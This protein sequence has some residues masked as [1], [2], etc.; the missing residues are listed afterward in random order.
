MLR[1]HRDRRDPVRLP[2]HRNLRRNQ[3]R[4]GGEGLH[5]MQGPAFRG[6]GKR[7]TQRPAIDG[8]DVIRARG[9]QPLGRYLRSGRAL[10]PE[11]AG[12]CTSEWKC[13]L[14][15]VEANWRKIHGTGVRNLKSDSTRRAPVADR[16][17][18]RDSG[19][20][21]RDLSLCYVFRMTR[22][23]GGTP[24]HAARAPRL[25]PFCLASVRNAD[26]HGRT[27]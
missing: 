19:F 25:Q 11:G 24:I 2:V 13:G 14:Y 26:A 3:L 12:R 27:R 23:P 20:L 9:G 18:G 5:Q 1:K 7:P 8:D 4:L 17:A 16:V 6:V 22:C 15:S 21:R 10:A